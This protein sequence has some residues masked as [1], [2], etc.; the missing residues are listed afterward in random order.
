MACE[1]LDLLRL[2]VDD[3]GGIVD[4]VID[5]LLVCLVDQGAKEEDRG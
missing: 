1:L 4:V 5:E 2:L 3:A